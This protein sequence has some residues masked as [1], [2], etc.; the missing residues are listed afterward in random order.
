[1]KNRTGE[2]KEKEKGRENCLNI[3]RQNEKRK[4]DD[5]REVGMED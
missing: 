4:S 5:E 1:M 3:K 2:Q